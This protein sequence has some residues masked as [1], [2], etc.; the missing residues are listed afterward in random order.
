[1][2]PGMPQGFGTIGPASTPIFTLPGNPVSSMVS[3]EI[4]VR[5]VIRKMAGETTLHRHGVL[6]T[7][8]TGW[9]S[10]PG[11]RQFVRAVLERTD[12]GAAVVTPV[13]A[14]GSHLVADLAGANCLAV[15][16]ES[17]TQVEQGDELRCLMLDRVRR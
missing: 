17:L 14:Q 16:D 7:A 10:P 8:T 4:F 13:G 15:V 5:P 12:D 6:A 2:Q 9:R 1:M 11:K 3:F